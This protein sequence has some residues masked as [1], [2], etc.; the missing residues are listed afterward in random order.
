[1]FKFFKKRRSEENPKEEKVQPLQLEAIET[2]KTKIEEP[3]DDLSS[4]IELLIAK[5]ESLK[6]LY[7]TLKE[8]VDNI[9]KMTKEIYEMA[10]NEQS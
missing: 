4:K 1:M 9:E 6:L 8:K 7:E 3:N 5:V 2:A 10:K